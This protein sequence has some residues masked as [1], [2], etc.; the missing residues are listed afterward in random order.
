MIHI[1]LPGV[2][3][4]WSAPYVGARG[5]FSKKTPIKNQIRPVVRE[6][7]DHDPLQCAVSVDFV[8]FMPIP[9]A[10]SK[11]KRYM[12]INDQVFHDKTPDR[13]NLVKFYEDVLQGIVYLNDSQ[14]I[15]GNAAKYYGEIPRTEIHIY[16]IL[17]Y[18]FK[19]LRLP[20]VS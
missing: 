7:Y 13:S 18:K 19:C 6:Q 12:M 9:K 20:Q 15:D 4:C 17:E 11:K 16:P 8:F 5:C 3:V 1:I 10:T 2:P 14:I